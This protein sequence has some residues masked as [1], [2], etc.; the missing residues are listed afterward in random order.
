[1]D[2]GSGDRPLIGYAS[3]VAHG[4]GRTPIGII[5]FAASHLL[6]GAV[7][8]LIAWIIFQQLARAPA[9]V[10]ALDWL[11]AALIALAGVPMLVG[12]VALLLKG[13]V[14]WTVALASFVLLA[15]F[16][17]IAIAY[18]V[19]MTVRYAWQNNPDIIWAGLFVVFAM[20]LGLLCAVV[21]GYLTGS[22]ARLTFGLPPGEA[23]RIL[24]SL[25]TIVLVLYALGALIGPMFSGVRMLFPD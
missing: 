25:R 12:G 13:S 18:A 24:K 11:A 1:V 17:A 3:H 6:L 20:L 10:T 22:K 23:P 2:L 4:T 21:V 9:R 14:A 19:A 16:E 8:L 7:L 5:L 15:I